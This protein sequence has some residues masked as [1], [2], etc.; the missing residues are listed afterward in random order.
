MTNSPLTTFQQRKG[1][2]NA[3]PRL[4]L[5]S[6]QVRMGCAYMWT[7]VLSI[8]AI[9]IIGTIFLTLFTPTHP[10]LWQLPIIFG[11]IIALG[12]FLFLIYAPLGGL[13]GLLTARRLT[14]RLRQL[15]QA[16]IAIADGEYR[17]R[18]PVQRKDEV[19][20]LEAQF[21]AMAQR[22]AESRQREQELVAQNVRLAERTRIAR[23]V[24]DAIS[25]NLFSLRLLARG[26]H[27]ALPTDS[28]LQAK[29]A[30]LEKTTETM[31]REMRALLL[32]L[33]PVQL[34]ALGLKEALEEVA[35]VYRSRLDL[36]IIAEIAPITLS[37]PLE[38]AILR[39]TQEALSNATRHAQATNITLT[40]TPAQGNIELMITD[41]GC[42]FDPQSK[43]SRHG[44]GLRLMQERVQGLHGTIIIQ[45]QPAT[46]TCIQITFP[47]EEEKL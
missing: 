23:E 37:T 13:F 3:L 16:T 9:I 25:Q 45:S 36:T 47:R 42:G 10:P 33:R 2:N 34:E 8:L 6:L 21:N 41:N 29:V 12:L 43:D 46:G 30:L 31:T 19:G 24:H 1:Y 35:E 20:I 4:G 22:L 44:L 26:M 40:L 27:T 17:L 14:K 28:P 11:S 15:A 5:A 7:N 39:I 32:E 38:H 18:I